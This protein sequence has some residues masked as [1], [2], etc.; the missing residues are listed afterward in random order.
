MNSFFLT[1]SGESGC[2]GS[3]EVTAP[4]LVKNRF[5]IAPKSPVA[6]E[7]AVLDRLGD[8]VGLDTFGA[9]QVGDGP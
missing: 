9:L 1:G 3:A 6:I 5:G 7:Q 8:V 4:P 2:P